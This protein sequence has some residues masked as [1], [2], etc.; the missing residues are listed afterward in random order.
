M[1]SKVSRGNPVFSQKA[2][3]A[4]GMPRPERAFIGVLWGRQGRAGKQL[5]LDWFEEFQHAW[6]LRTVPLV[7]YLALSDLGQGEYWR[8][9]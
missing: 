3:G 8:G 6:G 1:P 4:R 9:M 2:Q 5:R 7:W